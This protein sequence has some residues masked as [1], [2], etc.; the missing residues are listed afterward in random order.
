[1]RFRE[2]NAEKKKFEPKGHFLFLEL[3]VTFVQFSFVLPVMSFKYFSSRAR[4][5]N[6][7]SYITMIGVVS[8]LSKEK[9]T[10]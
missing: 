1:M 4:A 6:K 7:Y 10:A 9:T 8:V 2:L 3:F 5:N